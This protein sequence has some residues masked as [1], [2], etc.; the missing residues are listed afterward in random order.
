MSHCFDARIPDRWMIMKQ[1]SLQGFPA[2]VKVAAI[3][4]LSHLSASGCFSQ[5][6]ILPTLRSRALNASQ[7]AAEGGPLVSDPAA[8]ADSA[9]TCAVGLAG[10]TAAGLEFPGELDEAKQYRKSGKR[11]F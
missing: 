10:V 7:S 4:F 1:H 2:R 8:S 6:T 9:A 11:C 3:L 5:P